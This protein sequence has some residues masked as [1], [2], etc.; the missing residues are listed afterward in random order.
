M[1]FLF[2][3]IVPVYN[4][5]KYLQ[6]AVESVVNQPQFSETE[7]ILVD[8]GSTDSSPKIC[9]SF[10]KKY[11][12]VT[13]VHQKNSGVSV[14][15]N[16]GIKYAD[17]QRIMFLDADDYYLP[18]IFEKIKKYDSDLISFDFTKGSGGCTTE[19]IEFDYSDVN[20]F[21][22]KLYPAM[23]LSDAFFNCWNKVFRKDIIVD[24][25]IQ[26]EPNLKYGEDMK[27]VFQYVRCIKSFNFIREPLYFYNVNENS[28]TSKTND[29]YEIYKSLYLWLRE[30]FY[31]VDCDVEKCQ[32]LIESN[33]IY[34]SWMSL[35]AAGKDRFPDG[36]AKIR[37]T[38]NDELFISL[39]K[40]EGYGNFQSRY[41][42]A[43]DIL[44]RKRNALGLMIISKF[45]GRNKWK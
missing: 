34:K 31:S 4:C 19:L 9:D 18:N 10:A 23:A 45:Y 28:V 43:T 27:F 20:D 25:N 21:K 1:P 11:G 8:D 39:Y 40:K 26:F 36:L 3:V 13:A 12:N 29:D 16:N 35:S 7:L 5:E 33:F 6:R 41:D 14:A 22:E 37:K 38:V 42:K 24:N 30:Y 15:R 2:S 44:L 17:A 32:R